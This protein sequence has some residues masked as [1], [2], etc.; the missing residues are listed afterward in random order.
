MR[1]TTYVSFKLKGISK[2]GTSRPNCLRFYL[3]TSLRYH[4]DTL[5]YSICSGYNAGA[6]NTHRG[7]DF[8]DRRLYICLGGQVPEH[9]LAQ[10]PHSAYVCENKGGNVARG[11]SKRS[12]S[13][14]EQVRCDEEIQRESRWRE[15]QFVIAAASVFVPCAASI[16]AKG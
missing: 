9:N 7:I 16:P 14:R 1:K 6:T 11:C 13:R 8:A 3:A 15:L 5:Q 12:D 10:E 2:F 4:S